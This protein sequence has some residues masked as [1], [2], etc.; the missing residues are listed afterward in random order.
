MD[1]ET[2]TFFTP[3]VAAFTFLVVFIAMYA[4]YVWYVG[5][6]SV[7]VPSYLVGFQDMPVPNETT[8]L[9]VVQ[10]ALKASE[11][12]ENP[13][14]S[15]E[16]KKNGGPTDDEPMPPVLY[17]LEEFYGGAARGTGS[18]DCLRSSSEGAA[19]IALFK[20][21]CTSSD[22]YELAKIAG[23]LSC[24][25]KDLTSPSYIVDATRN[26]EYVTMHDIEPIAE[27]T[28]RC[29]TKTISERDI[30]LSFDKWTQRGELLIKRLGAAQK[31][32][33]V[34]QAET[35]FRSLVRDVKDIAR[36][37]CFVGEP[38]IAGKP[39]PRDPHPYEDPELN[40]LGPYSGYY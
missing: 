26:Q 21:D 22:Y 40:D 8:R 3:A 15:E 31:L 30:E 16:S 1:N 24:F 6:N 9:G 34:D 11:F 23:K 10:D 17:A 12:F 39:G 25:K 37:A 4:A 36:G 38:R 2:N 29:F 19:L 5:R 20:E 14:G 27:T 28:G 13:P 32:A 33:S 7:P 18:P 35:L